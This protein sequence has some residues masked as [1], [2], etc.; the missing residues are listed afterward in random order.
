MQFSAP[1]NFAVPNSRLNRSDYALERVG[2]QHAAPHLG[3]IQTVIALPLGPAPT[4]PPSHRRRF[5]AFTYSLLSAFNCRLAF[6]SI[7]CAGTE[8]HPPLARCIP[9][10]PAS[11]A[12]SLSP[13]PNSPPPANHSTAQ[14]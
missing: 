8:S 12:P 13:P 2:A 3:K 11:P 4:N 9:S 10:P 7:H 6:F 5:P 14:L 1:S